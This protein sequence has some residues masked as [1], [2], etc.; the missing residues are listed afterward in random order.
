MAL[1]VIRGVEVDV[2]GAER[3]VACAQLA[4]L[5]RSGASRRAKAAGASKLPTAMISMREH[6]TGALRYSSLRALCG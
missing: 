5:G 2:S 4:G 1:Q 3:G 6:V